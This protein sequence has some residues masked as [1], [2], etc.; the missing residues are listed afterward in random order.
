MNANRYDHLDYKRTHEL[1]E[2]HGVNA[3]IEMIR[4]KIRHHR[5]R[6]SANIKMRSDV[7]ETEPPSHARGAK[8]RKYKRDTYYHISE[9]YNYN[10]MLQYITPL[11][12]L[13][14][15]QLRAH[16]VWKNAQEALDEMD[17]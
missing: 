12:D 16:I 2:Q 6:S 11:K 15:E 14:P 9:E 7:L 3:L 13:T 5:E 10:K 8:L 17:D 4:P 1:V